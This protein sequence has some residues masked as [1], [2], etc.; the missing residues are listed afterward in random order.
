MEQTRYLPVYLQIAE[1]VKSQIRGQDLIPGQS[2]PNEHDFA[3]QFGVARATLRRA[4]SVLEKEGFVIRRKSAGTSVAPD[5][6]ENR[7]LKV[8]VAYVSPA[9][10]ED[11]DHRLDVVHGRQEGSILIQ[12]LA[13]HG[14]MLRFVPWNTK[15]GW[16]DPETILF[17]KGIDGFVLS[18]PKRMPDFVQAV[19]CAKRP[20]VAFESHVDVY[21]VNTVM[22]ADEAA[23]KQAVTLLQKAGYKRLGLIAGALKAPD[24]DSG[25]RRRWRG[26]V[27]GCQARQLDLRDDWVRTAYPEARQNPIDYRYLDELCETFLAAPELPEAVVLAHE[28]LVPPFCRAAAARQLVIPRD[29]SVLVL[30]TGGREPFLDQVDVPMDR[31]SCLPS[32]LAERALVELTSWIRDPLYRPACHCL[33]FTYISGQSLTKPLAPGDTRP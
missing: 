28:E 3:K 8:D 17:H 13:R 30:S 22:P 31:L 10:E 9:T 16:Y 4:L 26:F 14:H 2:L 27:D 32:Q 21:G 23:A 29:I 1:D 18:R 7:N 12:S 6:L 25:Y 11:A 24:I 15:E 20:H 33:P 5:A 19:A